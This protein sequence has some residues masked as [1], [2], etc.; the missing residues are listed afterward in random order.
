[1]EKTSNY[2]NRKSSNDLS[3]QF[4][5][6]GLNVI[7]KKELQEISKTIPREGKTLYNDGW[8]FDLKSKEILESHIKKFDIEKIILYNT[9]SPRDIEIKNF[10]RGFYVSKKVVF[11]KFQKYIEKEYLVSYD[12]HEYLDEDTI[13][14][15]GTI[16]V[17]Y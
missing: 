2:D 5:V 1:M 17:C 9:A 15:E 4:Y 8:V 12:K 7:C 16:L 10:R 3:H 14:A 11:K 6:S 13:L